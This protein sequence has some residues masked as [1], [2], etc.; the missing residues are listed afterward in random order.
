MRFTSDQIRILREKG[1]SWGD[2]FREIMSSMHPESRTYVHL[3]SELTRVCRIDGA[4]L[5]TLQRWNYWF[6]ETGYDDE[7]L[8]RILEGRIG[9]KD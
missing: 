2:V 5:N 1:T 6:E 4:L 7:E 8:E 3:F 9:I